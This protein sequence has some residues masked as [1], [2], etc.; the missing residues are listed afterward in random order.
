MQF[1]YMY[2]M[3]EYFQATPGFVGAFRRA[4]NRSIDER[5]R[6]Q[7]FGINYAIFE[8]SEISDMI[9]LQPTDHV[10]EVGIDFETHILDQS[11]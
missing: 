11:R 9:R 1:L 4:L 10:I 5:Y 2:P 7:G 8:G 6:Q 3:A